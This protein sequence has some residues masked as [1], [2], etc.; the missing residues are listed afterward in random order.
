V[1]AE[2]RIAKLGA[3]LAR[4]TERARAPRFRSSN[5]VPSAAAPPIDVG[6]ESAADVDD[7]LAASADSVRPAA[8][9]P[10]AAMAGAESPAPPVEVEI[11][12][13]TVV[14]EE[15]LESGADAP[16]ATLRDELS[17]RERMVVAS[18][19]ALADLSVRHEGDEETRQIKIGVAQTGERPVASAEGGAPE[20]EEDT[21]VPP[22]VAPVQ[23]EEREEPP[24]SSRR[25]IAIE[26]KLEELAFGE[27]AP[28]EKPHA[29]PP[30][31]GRQVAAAPVELDFESE[32]T[33]V[34]P[35]DSEPASAPAP[36][37]SERPPAMDLKAPE[38]TAPRHEGGK[39][40]AFEGNVPVFKP[41]TFGELLE[42]TL[43][44]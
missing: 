41:A 18:P 8:A 19:T 25:P 15:L 38:V 20:L 16:D 13:E 42:A 30:E 37:K 24:A 44:L 12:S 14:D 7:L 1:S 22:E 2:E 33:G 17:S 43:S 29:P 9:E 27:A 31:S 40:A 26:P 36:K 10:V 32:F 21:E 39:A 28:S 5:G 3:L 35:R 34:R 11:V 23:S 6:G 4:V